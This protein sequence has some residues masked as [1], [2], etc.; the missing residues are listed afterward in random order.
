MKLFYLPREKFTL[1]EKCFRE[2][3]A[4]FF[5]RSFTSGE[6]LSPF[7]INIYFQRAFV[8]KNESLAKHS[9]GSEL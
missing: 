5:Y 2:F 4:S 6:T 1:C 7:C 9:I 3:M 8:M